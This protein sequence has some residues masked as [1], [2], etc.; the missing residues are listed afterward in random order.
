MPELDVKA[1]IT[2][3][4]TSA[5]IGIVLFL[6][7]SAV[8]IGPALSW[9]GVA[10]N[11]TLKSIWYDD[12]AE[13][14]RR[15]TIL[16]FIVPLAIFSVVSLL[17]V[18]SWYWF[19]QVSFDVGFPVSLG[20]ILIGT[21]W[22]LWRRLPDNLNSQDKWGAVGSLL[23]STFLSM[24]MFLPL[25]IL[26]NAIVADDPTYRTYQ[27]IWL[28]VIMCMILAYNTALVKA[29]FLPVLKFFLALVFTLFFIS[30]Y[31]P[32]PRLITKAS[33]NWFR[34]GNIQHASL[35]LDEV[36]CNIS[37]SYGLSVEK[38]VPDPKTCVLSDVIILSRLGTPYYIQA[39]GTPEKRLTM[40]A[41]NIL[42]WSVIE[43]QKPISTGSP[44][45]P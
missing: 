2:L 14:P 25:L 4:T 27:T 34:F 7:M 21:G 13:F 11:K 6:I 44:Q 36:G 19:G 18:V 26:V 9:I 12:G 22:H 42:S 41:A 24:A 15:S 5:S 20:L 28:I 40:P 38:R 35:I 30:F 10:K 1:S 23:S 8:L 37:R 45:N 32:F 31:I 16:W 43:P 39:A 17:I 33:M 3:L 29:T